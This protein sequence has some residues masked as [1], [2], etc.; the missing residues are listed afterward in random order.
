MV[1]RSVLRF[2]F[3]DS[4]PTLWHAIQ[5]LCVSEFVDLFSES[6]WC[7]GA[8]QHLAQNTRH[9]TTVMADWVA[10]IN[11]HIEMMQL[12]PDLVVNFDETDVPFDLP[13]STTLERGGARTVPV[14]STGSPNR[15]T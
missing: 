4:D 2:W 1:F 14:G 3:P 13:M 9:C 6:S 12:S 15:A 10:A 8:E 7:R 11:S 5:L